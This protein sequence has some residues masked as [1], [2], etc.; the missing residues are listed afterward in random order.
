MGV[1]INENRKAGSCLGGNNWV[2]VDEWFEV[3]EGENK[4]GEEMEKMG[5]K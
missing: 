2:M 3:E 1:R 4:Y 5:V